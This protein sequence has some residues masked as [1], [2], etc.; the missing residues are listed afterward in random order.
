MIHFSLS[1]FPEPEPFPLLL[2]DAAR[3]SAA[4]AALAFLAALAAFSDQL[5]LLLLLSP[6]VVACPFVVVF[7]AG[8]AAAPAPDPAGL[9][10]FAFVF[11]RG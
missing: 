8:P 3:D 4:A 1:F 11:C 6:L 7:L 9:V 2:E 5:P 10:G